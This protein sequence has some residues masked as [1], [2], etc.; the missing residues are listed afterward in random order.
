MEKLKE[1]YYE[2]FRKIHFLERYEKLSKTFQNFDKRMSNLDNKVVK[3]F[4]KNLGYQVKIFSP[5][6]DFYFDESNGDFKFYFEI[7]KKGGTLLGRIDVYYQNTLPKMHTTF[8]FIYRVLL[9]KMD[10][11]LFPICY[12]NEHEFEAILKE[13]LSIYEDFKLEFLKQMK[14][15]SLA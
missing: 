4:F 10:I 5:G 6:Q 12:T 14:E 3:A 13:F 9:E 15:V 11:E 8:H 1:I 7:N 2:S